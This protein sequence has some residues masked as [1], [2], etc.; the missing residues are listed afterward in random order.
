M[1]I[2]TELFIDDEEWQAEREAD[3]EIERGFGREEQEDLELDNRDREVLAHRERSSESGLQAVLEQKGGEKDDW[4]LEYKGDS[5]YR[6][7]G[8]HVRDPE[9]NIWVNE[10]AALHQEML[11]QWSEGGDSIFFLPDHRESTGESET[12]YV[13]MM[14]LSEAG[15]VT[16][17][18]R[19]YET[20]KAAYEDGAEGGE[21]S[22]GESSPDRWLVDLL[23]NNDTG[24]AGAEQPEALAHARA[25]SY[26]SERSEYDERLEH[27]EEEL[28]RAA[29]GS[30]AEEI[31]RVLGIPAPA[32]S[33][34]AT[35][36]R[37]MRDDPPSMPPTRSA[38]IERRRDVLSARTERNGV[39][40]E[41]AA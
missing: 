26:E 36:F 34:E 18:I 23:D 40:M 29:E 28:P 39:T 15:R 35:G 11:S 33:A 24:L 17:E 2:E 20:P 37:G 16:Y 25:S 14:I 4:A 32:L 1:N 30:K 10:D 21:R 38:R 3:T 7:D 19:K 27:F 8:E 6:F 12:L 5:G 31:L 9:G 41:M 13:T 22:G